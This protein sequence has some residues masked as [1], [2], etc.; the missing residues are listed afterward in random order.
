MIAALVAE[1]RCRNRRKRGAPKIFVFAIDLSDH[2]A[3]SKVQGLLHALGNAFAL[4]LSYDQSIDNGFNRMLF[5][6]PAPSRLQSQP[7]LR[8][9]AGGRTRRFERNRSNLYARLTID[10]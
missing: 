3:L 2:D 10:E 4:T 7:V 8:R 6:Y 9:S 5:L 1:R